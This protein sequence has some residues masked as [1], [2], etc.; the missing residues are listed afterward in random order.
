MRR[1]KVKF[2]MKLHAREP[3]KFDL[4][5]TQQVDRYLARIE[6]IVA[7]HPGEGVFTYFDK[8]FATLSCRGNE[9]WK[10][11]VDE[12]KAL[13]DAELFRKHAAAI[14]PRLAPVSG[15]EIFRRR[16][17]HLTPSTKNERRWETGRGV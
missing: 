1:A 5:W 11:V 9:A 2:L 14:E 3:R 15:C 13:I 6:E 7:E 17:E 16:M 4:A 12:A 8:E 10:D